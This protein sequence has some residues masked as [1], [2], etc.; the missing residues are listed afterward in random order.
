MSPANDVGAWIVWR[1]V[2]VRRANGRGSLAT[3]RIYG[4]FSSR[5]EAD[6]CALEVAQGGPCYAPFLAHR[7]LSSTTVVVEPRA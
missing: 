6:A 3:Q 4:E 2:F 5:V 7:E 1:T